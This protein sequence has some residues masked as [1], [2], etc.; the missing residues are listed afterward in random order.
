MLKRRETDTRFIPAGVTDNR[1]N[2]PDYVRVLEGL[3]GWQKRAGLDD[4]WDITAGQHITNF[5]HEV[6]V[7]AALDD[8]RGVE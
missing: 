4:D 3:T 5:R 7:V 6:H 1:W 8:T 2:N